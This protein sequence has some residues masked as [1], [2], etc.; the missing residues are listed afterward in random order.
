MGSHVVGC[1]GARG[2]LWAACGWLC[3]CQSGS[4]GGMWSHVAGYVGAWVCLGDTGWL[5]SQHLAGWMRR[6]V[7]RRHMVS[8]SLCPDMWVAV[9]ASVGTDDI[10]SLC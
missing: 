9:C 10:G 5:V 4:V 6:R 8:M 3:G 1:V 2:G 7:G